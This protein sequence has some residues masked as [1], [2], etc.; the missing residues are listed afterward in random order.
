MAT[1][2]AAFF[3]EITPVKTN[4]FLDVNNCGYYANLLHTTG[5]IRPYG[6]KDYQLIYITK[7]EMNFIFD[8]VPTL[9]RAG[10]VVLYRPNQPQ[11]YKGSDTL[12]TSYCWI[13]FSGTGTDEILQ[14]ASL[15]GKQYFHIGVNNNISPMIISLIEEL[16][17]KN[18]C[19]SLKV[20][21]LFTDI[22]TELCRTK[23]E[24]TSRQ[25]KLNKI[26]PALKSID[27]DTSAK[28]SNSDYA[29]LCDLNP[30]HFIHL[31]KE[32]MG[33]SPAKYKSKILMEKAQEMLLNS[34]LNISEIAES[35][36]F[37]DPLYF[38]KKFKAYFGESP[39]E[40]RK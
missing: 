38:S 33:T 11:I 25:K 14:A 24:K 1:Y 20:F 21:S 22:L 7:G 19:Y 28:L 16:R 31:F 36:G 18:I 15:T 40:Y 3:Q 9:L 4:V 10:D 39:T 12:Q 37:M 29:S 35:L 30:Y 27:S 17:H 13:H 32:V 34:G 26:M 6:R 8:G 5:T 2:H 23:V